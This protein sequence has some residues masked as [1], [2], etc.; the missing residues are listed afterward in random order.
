M[1]KL[2][3]GQTNE[4]TIIPKN[5]KFPLDLYDETTSEVKQLLEKYNS[6]TDIINNTQYKHTRV[7]AET[8]NNDDKDA[9]ARLETEINRKNKLAVDNIIEEAHREK[10]RLLHENLDF[11]MRA[12]KLA[13]RKSENTVSI[14]IA[15]ATMNKNRILETIGEIKGKQ[16]WLS[17]NMWNWRFEEPID[18][19]GY[20][21]YDTFDMGL[22]CCTSTTLLP[23]ILIIGPTLGLLGIVNPIAWAILFV[24]SPITIVAAGC[25]SIYIG[26][27]IFEV[28]K[29]CVSTIRI[30]ILEHEITALNQQFA[31]KIEQDPNYNKFIELEQEGQEI[32]AAFRSLTITKST[33]F[34]NQTQ[35]DADTSTAGFPTQVA[36]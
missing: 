5:Y 21:H 8:T 7:N 33:F 15:R 29:A 34:T 19:E 32:K 22:A 14:R 31:L 25:I 10:M 9:V 1:R 30:A 28:V 16:D 17:R 36:A 26:K 4:T 35:P 11:F 18:D 13:Y 23:A 2:T 24:T 12:Y 20:F 6:I 3:C 27:F